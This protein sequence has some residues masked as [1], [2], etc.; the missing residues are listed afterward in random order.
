MLIDYKDDNFIITSQIIENEKETNIKVY[1]TT[2]KTIDECISKIS[3]LSN[4]DIFISHLKIIILTED[5]IKSKQDYY[6]YFLR[7]TKSKMNF[8]I[9][10]ISNKYK[11]K[12]MNIYK[13]NNGSSLYLKDMIK[14]N[15]NIYSSSTKLSFLDLLYKE[16]E[17][18][19]PIY[20]NIEI[21]DDELLYLKNL[22]IFDDKFNKIILD[23]K[24][25]IYYNMLTNNL[26]KST[27]TIPCN[28]NSFSIK[29]NKSK[30]K[31]KWKN[32]TLYINIK[33]SS[34]MN[35]YDCKYDLNKS[36]TIKKL[37]SISDEQITK[38]I[39]DLINKSKDNNVDFIGFNNYIYKHNNKK[40]SNY[41]IKVNVNTTITSIGELR[42]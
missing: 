8:D 20:P 3:E 17:H 21:K 34:K 40:I 13:D 9:Y 2:G 10:Y 32:N 42:K 15:N 29:I 26:N 41:N 14:F 31:F 33:L 4:K 18:I 16:K 25:G 11:D 37:S 36:N 5:L 27:L 19:T 30:T 12:I 28:N 23:D 7:N 39:N 6:D 1:K 22:I 38:N 24:E 35:N